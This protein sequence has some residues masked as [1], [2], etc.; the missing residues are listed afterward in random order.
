MEWLRDISG[1]PVVQSSA[2]SWILIRTGN[3]QAW[4]DPA[5]SSRSAG[6][7]NPATS[8]GSLFW[9]P[10]SVIPHV[11]PKHTIPEF[12]VNLVTVEKIHLYF[13]FGTALKQLWDTLRSLSSCFFVRVSKPSSASFSCHLLCSKQGLLPFLA[14]SSSSTSL[15]KCRDQ[16]QIFNINQDI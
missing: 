5:E 9:P 6:M 13:F 7:E 4:L 3:G 1:S 10:G 2:E 14:L 8:P 15:L 11:W 16:N 12:A